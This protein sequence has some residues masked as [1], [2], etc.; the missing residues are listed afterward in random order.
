MGAHGRD[1]WPCKSCCCCPLGE[2]V[3][4]R[5]P[6]WKMLQEPPA[7]VSAR[8]AR[9]LLLCMLC[10]ELQ[11]D[12]PRPKTWCPAASRLACVGLLQLCCCAMCCICMQERGK[13]PTKDLGSGR[14]CHAPHA[15]AAS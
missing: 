2:D 4:R 6:S 11:V 13:K 8:D 5:V 15:G 14:E 10:A 3:L 12:P 1:E 7:A 9:L